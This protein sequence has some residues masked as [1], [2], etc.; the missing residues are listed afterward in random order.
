ML[1]F[2]I[3]PWRSNQIFKSCKDDVGTIVH[4]LDEAIALLGANLSVTGL[5]LAMFEKSTVNSEL[6]QSNCM[7]GL[8]RSNPNFY[9]RQ[10][11]LKL[12]KE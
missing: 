9:T 5:N 7:N 4:L 6:F 10:D 11:K 12:L 3:C 1:T 8:I 2:L